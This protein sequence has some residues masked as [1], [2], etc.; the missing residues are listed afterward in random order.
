MIKSI[1][2]DTCV[3][4]NIINKRDDDDAILLLE[5]CKKHRIK[6]YCSSRVFTSDTINMDD[7]QLISLKEIIGKYNVQ[8]DQAN[9]RIGMSP[10]GSIFDKNET[11]TFGSIFKTDREVNF[12]KVFGEDPTTLPKRNI[13]KKISN[14]IGDY[15]SLKY[16]YLNFRDLYVTKDKKIYMNEKMR[17]IA[18]KD[19]NLVILSP[20]EAIK[21]ISA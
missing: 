11:E 15:D 14:W 13:G 6:L 17:K 10:L 18:S 20:I 2:I 1:T 16:H 7:E 3:W 9:F 19:L 4:I 12:T 21:I 8:L 5:T